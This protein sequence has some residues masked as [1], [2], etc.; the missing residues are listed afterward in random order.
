LNALSFEQVAMKVAG[1][2]ESFYSRDHLRH[3]IKAGGFPP[4]IYLSPKRQVW[5]EA[6][7]DRYLAELAAKREQRGAK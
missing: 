4:P 1:S 2:V 6:E 3:K 7:I 5:L